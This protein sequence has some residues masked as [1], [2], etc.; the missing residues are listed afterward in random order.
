M[1]TLTV[2]F[3]DSD[4][5][6]GIFYPNNYLI[7]V[8]PDMTAAEHAVHTL[9]NSG[10]LEEDVIAVP[11]AEIV[12]FAGELRTKD[13]VWSLLMQQL[14]R[15]F[16]TEERYT[17]HDLALAAAGAAFVAVYCPS[18]KLKSDAWKILEP[19]APLVARHYTF[20]GIE[21]LKGEV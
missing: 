6:F 12:C 21:H 4:T 14:S 1:N 11:G 10:F 16:G 7:A 2:F 5:Q 15:A 8:F 3:K 17:S 18:E 20:G 9:R 19:A 13:G